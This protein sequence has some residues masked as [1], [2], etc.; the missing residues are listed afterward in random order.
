M[1]E[2]GCADCQGPRPPELAAPQERQSRLPSERP[3]TAS[4]CIGDT[5]TVPP[6]RRPE[7]AWADG[8]TGVIVSR[9]RDKV[10]R[11]LLTTENGLLRQARLTEEDIE[12][13][14]EPEWSTPGNGTSCFPCGRAWSR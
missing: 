7:L 11:V 6:N 3:N 13:T 12:P 14:G 2:T 8:L 5:I 4:P 9:S 1:A 10:I